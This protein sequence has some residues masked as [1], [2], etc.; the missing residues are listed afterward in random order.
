[1]KKKCIVIFTLLLLLSGCGKQEKKYVSDVYPSEL[2]TIENVSP[3]LEYTPEMTEERSRRMSAARYQSNPV[4]QGDPVIVK[5]YQ[6]NGLQSAEQVKAFYDECKAM[7]PDAF[8]VELDAEDA[9]IAYPSLHYY[10]DGYHIEIT[11]GSGSDDLQKVL[12][13]NLAAVS[14]ENFTALTGISAQTVAESEAP[15]PDSDSAG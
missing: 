2:L 8:D 11:A 4:G 9:F 14:I 15:S 10:I 12:L 6:K 5:V 7:R 13:T 1:M 3:Y